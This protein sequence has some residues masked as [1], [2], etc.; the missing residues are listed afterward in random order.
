MSQH[1]HNV[2]GMVTSIPHH[3]TSLLPSGVEEEIDLL[4]EELYPLLSKKYLQSYQKYT[5]ESKTQ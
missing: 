1:L 5:I 3:H 2:I 4:V